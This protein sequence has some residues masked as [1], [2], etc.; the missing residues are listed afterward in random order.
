MK[1]AVAHYHEIALKGK[2]RPRFVRQLIRNIRFAMNHLP[3]DSVRDEGGRLLLTFADDIDPHS[4]RER[5]RSVFGIAHFSLGETGSRDISVLKKEIGDRL[6]GRGSLR[7][8]VRTQRSDKTY[9]KSSMEID[10]EIGAYLVER[11][12][13]PVQLKDPELT[14]Y[15]QIL[16][17]QS[18]FHFEKIEGAGGLP[19]GISGKV[20]VLISGGIDSPVAAYRMMQRGCSVSFAHFHSY[21][22]LSKASLE[23]TEELMKL[24]VRHQQRIDLFEIPF[25]E[26]QQQVVAQAPAALRVVLYRRLMM[27][28]AERL[29]LR[30]RASA[31]VT[32]ES[33]GQV[34]SQTL[35]NLCVVEESVGMPI[36]R[37]LIGM[38]K[39]EIEKKAQ[40]IGT[41]KISIEEDQD[42]CQ[43]FI[44]RHPST[45]AKR[46]AVERA[47]EALDLEAIVE[48]G[49]SR[50]VLKRFP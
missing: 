48:Q 20:M 2:N 24:F 27:R 6:E 14:V 37:P 50:A 43:L 21:P 8:C 23:K 10:R 5:L 36:L 12:G 39:S 22:F 38:D 25:G 17:R 40:K 28:I 3:L 45:G 16:P 7:F 15:V 30:E 44:P 29:A 34:A 19:V 9:P 13:W 1:H 33:L 47:E 18:F 41:Y 49:V 4:V 26:I 42:C 32:G 46:K 31:L 11:F 35:R